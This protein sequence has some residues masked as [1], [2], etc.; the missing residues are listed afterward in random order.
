MSA[1]DDGVVWVDLRRFGVTLVAEPR[2]SSA[3]DQA[4]RALE[5]KVLEGPCVV[6]VAAVWTGGDVSGQTVLDA[7]WPGVRVVARPLLKG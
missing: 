5:T 2:G 4:L 3:P 1:D 7:E 6:N